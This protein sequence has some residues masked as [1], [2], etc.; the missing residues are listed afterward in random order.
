MSER[1]ERFP[2]REHLRTRQSF[3]RVYETGEARRGQHLIV[4]ARREPGLDR[5]VGFVSSRKVGNAVRR[6]RARRLMREAYRR[7]RSDF[8]PFGLE[9]HVVFVARRSI[10][11]ARLPDVLDE[12][13]RLLASAGMLADSGKGH[14]DD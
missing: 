2:A 3:R 14:A 5:K 7:L 6:N 4:I 1:R 10:V 11:D 9:A 13:R 12:M 8:T